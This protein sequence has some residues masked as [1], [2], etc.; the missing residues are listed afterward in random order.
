MS[1]HSQTHLVLVL[2]L[3][4]LRNLVVYLT[5]TRLR[6]RYQKAQNRAVLCTEAVVAM[7]LRWA[8]HCFA[9]GSESS[10]WRTWEKRL[11]RTTKE[12]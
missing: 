3:V 11:S 6:K 10:T 2:L 1:P 8:R 5:A 9:R 4:H 7:G 12:G